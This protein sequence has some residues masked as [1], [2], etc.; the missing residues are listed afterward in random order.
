MVD[1]LYKPL[2]FRR[3]RSPRVIHTRQMC[4]A[5]WG[6]AP[7]LWTASLDR[8]LYSAAIAGRRKLASR[9]SRIL[10][11][12]AHTPLPL[13]RLPVGCGTQFPG[14]AA[15]RT[16]PHAG[17]NRTARGSLRFRDDCR[18]ATGTQMR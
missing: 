1:T 12:A 6:D 17:L 2:P 10:G 18:L 14:P 9:V 13:E 15:L 4:Q 16:T 8:L 5:T 3:V 11:N 7:L